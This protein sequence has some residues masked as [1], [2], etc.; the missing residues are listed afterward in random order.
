MVDHETSM[1]QPRRAAVLALPTF[2]ALSILGACAAPAPDAQEQELEALAAKA[3]AGDAEAAYRLGSRLRRNPV[4]PGAEELGLTWLQRAA[5]RNQRDALIALGDLAAD[6]G[7]VRD[8]VRPDPAAALD[9]YLRAERLGAEFAFEAEEPGKE[10]LRAAFAANQWWDPS[11]LRSKIHRQQDRLAG[12][13]VPESLAAMQQRLVVGG[14]TD[15]EA[16]LRLCWHQEG[17]AEVRARHWQQALAMA[18]PFAVMIDAWKRADQ[19]ITPEILAAFADAEHRFNELYGE[20]SHPLLRQVSKFYART[21]AGLPF[22][23]AMAALTKAWAIGTAPSGRHRAQANVCLARAIANGFRADDAFLDSLVTSADIDSSRCAPFGALEAA[24]LYDAGRDAGLALQLAKRFGAAHEQLPARDTNVPYA[25]RRTEELLAIAMA[26]A[27]AAIKA[28][29]RTLLVALRDTILRKGEEALP[30]TAA[31]WLFARVKSMTESHRDLYAAPDRAAVDA[32]IAR[33]CQQAYGNQIVALRTRAAA[34][35]DAAVWSLAILEA[36]GL[37]LPTDRAAARAAFAALVERRPQAAVNV[38]LLDL[39]GAF[40][41]GEGP[42]PAMTLAASDAGIGSYGLLSNEAGNLV[43]AGLA[44]LASCANDASRARA[45]AVLDSALATLLATHGELDHRRHLLFDDGPRPGAPE[46]DLAK[47]YEEVRAFNA[48]VALER[49]QVQLDFTKA[50]LLGRTGVEAYEAYRY[51]GVT[52]QS[53]VI[54]TRQVNAWTP[55]MET[56]YRAKMGPLLRR[57]E[58]A[59]ATR[60]RIAA[61]RLAENR[62]RAERNQRLAAARVAY[63]AR[64]AEHKRERDAIGA[65]QAM[66]TTLIADVRSALGVAR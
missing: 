1:L 9:H 17:T 21:C 57:L 26:G 8:Q 30:D 49:E 65:A 28:E 56:E 48:V 44:A 58:Q 50:N 10:A 18:H 41:H 62:A 51:D 5:A 38:A 14:A 52:H 61:P 13:T 60:D 2:A 53:R 33:G 32:R 20:E 42:P 45:R 19:D 22:G 59:V 29:A 43:R 34:G 64:A 6:R 12:V 40:Q 47:G 55:A 3:E 31:E 7:F 36:N 16:H 39:A 23:E 25:G 15:A 66:V 37:G 11:H 35:D 63:E 46:P 4:T 54:G 24:A 27:D